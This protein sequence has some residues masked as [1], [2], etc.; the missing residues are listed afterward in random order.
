MEIRDPVVGYYYIFGINIIFIDVYVFFSKLFGLF[1][2][3][4]INYDYNYIEYLVII[5]II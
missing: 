2:L 3:N 4:I 1:S 5:I